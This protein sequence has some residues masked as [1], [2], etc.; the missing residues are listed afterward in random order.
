MDHNSRLIGLAFVAAWT[1][2]RLLRYLKV[3][4]SKRP[5]TAVPGSAGVLAQP[6]ETAPPAPATA[7]PIGPS[8]SGS[9]GFP[10][11]VAGVLVWLA[12]N[13][14]IWG[15]L[16]LLPPLEQVPVMP[17]L[18]VGVLANFY[19]IYLARTAAAR[20]RRQAGRDRS[21]GGNPIS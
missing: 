6:V 8:D 4:L 2:F 15:C 5:S 13:A 14:V 9:G 20:L 10:A 3:G 18:V 17:R 21:A 19:L 16:F 11:G 12:G 1:L 7:S